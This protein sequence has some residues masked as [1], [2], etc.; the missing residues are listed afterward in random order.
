MTALGPNAVDPA[1]RPGVVT[2]A[3]RMS[4]LAPHGSGRRNQRVITVVH[5]IKS[6]EL[7][8]AETVLRRLAEGADRDRF[9]FEVVSLGAV[10]PV[11]EQLGKL[12]VPVSALD[13]TGGIH[14]PKAVQQISA[15]LRA[16]RPDVIQTWMYHGDLI[17]GV[18]ARLAGHRNIVWGLHAGSPPLEGASLVNRVGLKASASLSRRIPAR[19]ICC[20]ETT[21][22]RH[23]SLGYDTARMTVIPNGFGLNNATVDRTELGLDPNDFLVIR[24]G[25]DHPDKDIPTF[26]RSLSVLRNQGSAVKG[27]LVGAGLHK[28]NSELTR[29]IYR[30]GLADQVH[31][32]GPRDDVGL[33]LRAADVAVSSSRGGEGLPLVVGEAMAA[34][35]PV[36]ATDVGDS[37]LLI[38]DPIRVVSPGDHRGL[39]AAILRLVELTGAERADLGARDQERISRRWSLEKMIDGYCSV[40]RQLVEET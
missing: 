14:Y 18:A 2:T 39:A 33:L 32:L 4:T 26:L 36:V 30:A 15:I 8:G 1:F 21:S 25:R 19:I 29:E 3:R 6:L 7:G 22:R 24:V 20:S 5:V 34:G 23:A 38:D 12:G 10:G 40:Y 35:T 17:G 27:V 31:L 28:G 16:R 37:A 9:T 13:A 11:G